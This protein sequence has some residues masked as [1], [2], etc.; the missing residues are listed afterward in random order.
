MSE[1]NLN[2]YNKHI[3]S[4][5]TGLL[6]L[7]LI[8]LWVQFLLFPKGVDDGFQ[9]STV[10]TSSGSPLTNNPPPS[11]YHLFGSSAITETALAGYDTES[12]LNLI[13][14]GIFSS[15]DETAGMAY[16][17]TTSG[18]EKKFKVGDD[19]FGLA[20][21]AEVHDDYLIL[22]R[23]AKKER[24]SLH[25]GVGIDTERQAIRPKSKPSQETIKANNIRNFVKNS[26]DW[27]RTLDQQKFD[28]G[29]ISD[30]VSNVNVMQNSQGQI[31]GLR[32]SSMSQN[33]ALL[34]AGLKPND[35]ITAVNGTPITGG[36]LLKLRAQLSGTNNAQVTVLRNGK[37]INLNVNLSELQQ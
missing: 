30:I 32:V 23:G 12:Q 15:N 6:A 26:G 27:Q 18:E 7:M 25:K 11:S 28:P 10:P 16:I 21:L 24:L 4:L 13:L 9:T 33:D 14:T 31:T 36:N 35:Q 3:V 19:V 2:R 29:K 5:S 1:C 37:T 17:R 22:K 8:A 20:Q 34:K